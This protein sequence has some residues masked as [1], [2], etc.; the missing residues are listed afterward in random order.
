MLMTGERRTISRIPNH[1]VNEDMKSS[2]AK[3]APGASLSAL[4]GLGP[5]VRLREEPLEAAADPAVAL[6]GARLEPA[7]VQHRDHAAMLSDQA[8]CLKRPQRD[9]DGGSLHAQHLGQKL[10]GERQIVLAHPILRAQDPTATARFDVM[11]GVA[12]DALERLGQQSLDIAAKQLLQG[13]AGF[14]GSAQPLDWK[15]RRRA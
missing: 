2:H 9:A 6:A 1:S 5:L 3:L 15:P 4:A 13:R 11:D 10:M 14:C 8:G 12:G 7:P